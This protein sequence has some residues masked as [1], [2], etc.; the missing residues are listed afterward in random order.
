MQGVNIYI[1]IW[2]FDPENQGLKYDMVD[3]FSY[4]FTELPGTT[5]KNLVINGIRP[6]AKSK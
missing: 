3:E 2:D 4:D 1:T 5:A 6:V